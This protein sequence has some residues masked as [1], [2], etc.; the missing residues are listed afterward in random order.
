MHTILNNFNIFLESKDLLKEFKSLH[1][2]SSFYEKVLQIIHCNRR[3]VK[4]EGV[5]YL[6]PILKWS[7]LTLAI[8]KSLKY[9]SNRITKP[10]NKDLIWKFPERCSKTDMYPQAM[11]FCLNPCQRHAQVYKGQEKSFYILFSFKC[12]WAWNLYL[13]LLVI[14]LASVINCSTSKVFPALTC[15]LQSGVPHFQL[16]AG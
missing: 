3:A 5:N 4:T 6:G 8:I 2:T 12:S 7:R 1:W 11:E 10:Y 16:F 13:F 15:L 9:I 14:P